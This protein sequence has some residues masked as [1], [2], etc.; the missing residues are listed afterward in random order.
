MRDRWHKADWDGPEGVW[1][2][3]EKI[4]LLR[5]EWLL[6]FDA[7]GDAYRRWHDIV[8]ELQGEEEKEGKGINVVELDG[9]RGKAKF[10]NATPKLNLPAWKNS[11]TKESMTD[12]AP[13]SFQHAANGA[14]NATREPPAFPFYKFSVFFCREFPI[15]ASPA[16]HK[17]NSG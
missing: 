9:K 4:W 13:S 5:E 16:S 10:P 11:D 15:S 12:I 6:G 17:L 7:E 3:P 8:E 2:N 14:Q 1:K